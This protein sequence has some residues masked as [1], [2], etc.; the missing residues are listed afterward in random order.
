MWNKTDIAVELGGVLKARDAKC[1]G[2]DK[3]PVSHRLYSSLVF[4]RADGAGGVEQLG[5]GDV[6]EEHVEEDGD[7][8]P[9]LQP[10]G[11][12]SG[13]WLESDDIEE[14]LL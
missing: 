7:C 5:E 6:D 2:Q 12:G 13:G 8:R 3:A 4:K 14:Y 9:A 10:S 1:V 11:S